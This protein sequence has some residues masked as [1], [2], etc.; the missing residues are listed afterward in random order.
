ME[1]RAT[2]VGEMLQKVQLANE[3]DLFADHSYPGRREKVILKCLFRDI[4]NLALKA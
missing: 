2:H 4:E 1:H 3:A